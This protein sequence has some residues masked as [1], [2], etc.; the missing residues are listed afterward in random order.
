MKLH[1]YK[2]VAT[3]EAGK[4]VKGSL[5]AIDRSICFRF[6]QSKNYT[7]VSIREQDNILTA[8]S[9]ITIGSIM[10]TKQMVFF[11]K[12]LG[13]LLEA[14][15]KLLEALEMLALQQEKHLLRRLYFEIY[16]EV[17]NGNS[18]SKALANHPKEFPVLLVS[19][20]E[21]G[22]LS[23][24]L[25]DTILEMGEFYTKQSRVVSQI[26]STVRMPLIY[27]GATIL[28]SIGMMLF[29]FPNIE[30]LFA[31]FGEAELPGVTA[32]FI[33]SSHFLSANILYFLLGAVLLVGTVLL[34]N[35]YVKAIHYFFTVSLLKLP[36]FGEL[37]QM[38]NQILIANALGQM[39]K[40]EIN[41]IKALKTAKT[42]VKNEVYHR[43]V[44]KT[45]AYIEDGLPF[46][47]A[48]SESKYI[49][50]IMAK[51]IATGEKTGNVAGFLQNMATYY[52]EISDM[53]IEKI[54]AAIQPIMLLFVYAIVGVLLL[55]LMLP[56][57]SLGTQ[58]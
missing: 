51:M 9:Q 53:K 24:N 55:A 14:G 17:F 8:L 40:N 19:M 26:K 25:S 36:M 35:R 54:K 15:I 37:I 41:S 20:I 34:L 23:G 31:S 10:N 58:I 22:E 39:M 52:N 44:A 47:K 27:L 38:H 49:D 50:P 48:F 29:V 5:D 32:F 21:V 3:T 4:T 11:L 18:F 6:L 2:Y 33:N 12:Q 57:M 1:T 46:S 42:L 45:L 30:D 43:I 7:V 56:M 13:A 16:L 28:I